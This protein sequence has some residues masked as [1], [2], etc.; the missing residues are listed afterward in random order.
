MRK[1][2]SI[3]LTA[4]FALSSVTLS[5]MPERPV[6]PEPKAPEGVVLLDH[7]NLP[8]GLVSRSSVNAAPRK[9]AMADLMA[10]LY[11]GGEKIKDYMYT[12]EDYD[13]L[14]GEEG[15]LLDGDSLVIEIDMSVSCIDFYKSIVLDLNGHTICGYYYGIY[16]GC[17]GNFRVMNGSILSETYLYGDQNSYSYGIYIASGNVTL[18]DVTINSADKGGAGYAIAIYGGNLVMNNCIVNGYNRGVNVYSNSGNYINVTQT[19]GSVSGGTYGVLASY[20]TKYTLKSGQVSSFDTQWSYNYIYIYDGTVL[21]GITCGTSGSNYYTY[22]YIYGGTINS[23]IKYGN[24][25]NYVTITSGEIL[26]NIEELG[27]YSGGYYNKLTISGDP[28]IHGTIDA[29]QNTVSLTGGSYAIQ[30]KSSYLGKDYSFGKPVNG[31]YPLI[32]AVAETGGYGF[33]SVE[34]A[35]ADE[36]FDNTIKLMANVEN[37]TINK[38][39]TLDLDIRSITGTLTITDGTKVSVKSFD[40]GNIHELVATKADVTLYGGNYD[41]Q[42]STKATLADG[43][44][45][46]A[47]YP[48]AGKYTVCQAAVASIFR[49]EGT[50]EEIT[51]WTLQE[52]I[53]DAQAGEKILIKKDI[54][55]LNGVTVAKGKD[56]TIDLNGHVV[57]GQRNPTG[58]WQL[59]NVNGG[60]L[61]LMDNKDVNK[62]GTGKGKL[63]TANF[64]SAD[65]SFRPTYAVNLIRNAGTLIIESG[66]YETFGLGQAAYSID[67]YNTG[68]TT[69]NGGKVISLS[70]SFAIRIFLPSSLDNKFYINGGIIESLWVQ[71]GEDWDASNTKFTLHIQNAT[72]LDRLG[73]EAVGAEFDILLKNIVMTNHLTLTGDA[74]TAYTAGKYVVDSVQ[75]SGYNL[76][77]NTGDAAFKHL[78]N[79]IY[80]FEDVYTD[81]AYT[82][83][84]WREK[85]PEEEGYFAVPHPTE[86]YVIEIYKSGQANIRA[87]MPYIMDGYGLVCIDEE[88]KWYEIRPLQGPTGSKDV[89][90]HDDELGN[91]WH[92]DRTWDLTEDDVVPQDTTPVHIDHDVY[93]ETDTKADAASIIV[94]SEQTLTVQTGATLIVGN[95]G[96]VFNNEEG[97]TPGQ[98]II[99]PG[100]TLLDG[101]NGIISDDMKNV[102]IQASETEQGTFLFDP[103]VSLNTHP[104]GTVELISRSGLR[105][106]PNGNLVNYWH[107]FA[108]PVME[109]TADDF[110]NNWD[111]YS[112]TTG[113]KIAAGTYFQTQIFQWSTYQHDWQRI[114]DKTNYCDSIVPFQGYTMLNNCTWDNTHKGGVTYTFRGNLVGNHNDDLTFLSKGYNY[115]GNSYTAPIHIKEL[116]EAVDNDDINRTVY[117]WD[118][119]LQ[120]FR[121]WSFEQLLY[122]DDETCPAS[123]PSMQT[124]VMQLLSDN[125]VTSHIDYVSAIW[126]PV[127]N[128]VTSNK[129]PQKAQQVLDATLKINIV[130]ANGEKDAVVIM[131]DGRY[132]SQLDNGA[133]AEKYMN[134]GSVNLYAH[135]EFANVST[136][137]DAEIE[138]TKLS[139]VSND[140]TDYIMTFSAVS[141]EQYAIRDNFTGSVVTI[142]EGNTYAFSTN[143]NSTEENRFEIVAIRRAPTDSEKIS[144]NAA[145]KGIYSVTGQYVG[146]AQDWFTLPAGVY[147]MEGQ[148]VVK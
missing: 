44:D 33:A 15:D 37:A 21:G 93:V 39:A 46:R 64:S 17:T 63:S 67:Q 13:A 142:A 72:I 5:A 114:D 106:Y 47:D 49:G 140:E 128:A 80:Q 84:N 10:T 23:D 108:S 117:I 66:L 61:T 68:S 28:I 69:I 91:P 9:A 83:S 113:L 50:P 24:Y 8:H 77:A 54:S 32:K 132:S 147:V 139:L 86:P 134:N 11:R 60:K 25:Y 22:I 4:L 40:T 118:A 135:A 105:K 144:T 20:A 88:N 103:E 65:L 57:S 112:E 43:L 6:P 59:V 101:A 98:I 42:P 136:M 145:A 52:A 131:K 18:D 81:A 53:D 89:E 129:A 7:G 26:G 109:L 71:G 111:A 79:G 138:G 110:T 92:Q 123:I 19:G 74:R 41:F 102:V 38:D 107:R 122:V 137:A 146:E 87:F 62:D 124:F 126:E 2:N 78:K 95:G 35:L 121:G 55:I 115:F 100:A 12:Q 16:I 97:K 45:E 3:L 48:S 31:F 133:D 56:I 27:D 148:K 29:K 85:Y 36:V 120:V 70:S 58:G 127:V 1:L 34:E 94:E 116:L 30:P 75:I 73:I 119:E 76:P 104:F 51:Y 96:I 99:E 90:G 143:A 14:F 141:G 125:S 130:A 82:S